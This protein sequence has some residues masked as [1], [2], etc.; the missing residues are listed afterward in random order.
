MIEVHILSSVARVTRSGDPLRLPQ[1][2]AEDADWLS[3]LP[4]ACGTEGTTRALQATS[5]PL[6]SKNRLGPLAIHALSNPA[7]YID[8][9]V[10]GLMAAGRNVLTTTSQL[11][12]IDPMDGI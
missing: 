6:T 11:G 12:V 7:C 5:P 1:W 3:M 9:R 8:T 2:Q 4:A 10:Q